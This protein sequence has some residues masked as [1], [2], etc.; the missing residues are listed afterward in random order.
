MD[1]L[2]KQKCAQEK[3]KKLCTLHYRKSRRFDGKVGNLKEQSIQLLLQKQ[4]W[5]SNAPPNRRRAK[6]ILFKPLEVK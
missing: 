6:N 1:K 3:Q 5:L 2:L 4:T